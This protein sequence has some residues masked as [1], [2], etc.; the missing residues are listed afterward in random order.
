MMKTVGER[1][2]ALHH[3]VGGQAIPLLA[4]ASHANAFAIGQDFETFANKTDNIDRLTKSTGELRDNILSRFSACIFITY[5]A[6]FSCLKTVQILSQMVPLRYDMLVVYRYAPG[7][8]AEV[9]SVSSRVFI[10]KLSCVYPQQREW[11]LEGAITLITPVT[12]AN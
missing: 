1:G 6:L 8:C 4:A 12:P 3:S 5:N 10:N 9:R 11:P 2:H 7:C